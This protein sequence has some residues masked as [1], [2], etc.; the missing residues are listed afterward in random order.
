[1]P[2]LFNVI[3]IETHNQ[4]TRECWFC[5]FGLERKEKASRME[6]AVIEK[7]VANLERLG[8]KGRIS[9]YH[10]NEPLV[11]TRIYKI[12]EL[13]RE[14]CPHAFLGFNTNGDLLTE[15]I[16]QRLRQSGLDA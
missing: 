1:M 10:I 13:T 5:K 14:A 4:C 2:A 11:E 7:I 15:E 3:S 16:Y 8:Y 9:W 12:L 6:W